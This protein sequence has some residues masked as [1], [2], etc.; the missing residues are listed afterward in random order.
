MNQDERKLAKYN[1]VVDFMETT[2]RNPS[3]H[4]VEEHD[5]LNWLKAN[6]KKMNAGELKPKRVSCSTNYWNLV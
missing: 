4:R 2:H 3:L 5:M 6:R 1:E